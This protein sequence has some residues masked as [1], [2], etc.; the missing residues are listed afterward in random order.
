M[1]AAEETE[2]LIR[3]RRR[4]RARAQQAS[5]DARPRL[6]TRKKKSERAQEFIIYA[7]FLPACPNTNKTLARVSVCVRVC[8]SLAR[9]MGAGGGGGC[10]PGLKHLSFYPLF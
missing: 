8:T 1:E 7:D 3:I 5:A 4:A 9:K 2:G 6:L 10:P